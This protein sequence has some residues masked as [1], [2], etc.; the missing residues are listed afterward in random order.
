MTFATADFYLF[1][2]VGGWQVPRQLYR[3]IDIWFKLDKYFIP[4][5]FFL[6]SFALMQYLWQESFF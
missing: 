6:P 2:R 4:C 3:K 1:V 5:F